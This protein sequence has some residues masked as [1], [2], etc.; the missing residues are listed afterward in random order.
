MQADY[1]ANHGVRPRQFGEAG[2]AE[3]P[4]G[5]LFLCAGCRRQVIVCSCCDRGQ[6]YC[7]GGCAK[8]A[9]QRTVQRAGRRYQASHRGR[10]MHAARMSRWRARQQKVT[11]HGSPAPPAGDLLAPAAMTATRA[12]VAPAE[13]ARLPG[14][15]CHWCG[16]T[17][18]PL[19]RQRFL[20]RR[21][22]HRGRLA[23]DPTGPP[24]HGDA[25]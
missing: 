6:V 7:T 8:A 16:R 9:R 21:R 14:P 25:A 23:H 4:S 17:C 2:D 5:R 12:A 22:R 19:L 11:H 10:R 20:R 3:P 15:H 24:R 18:L 13:Q 1:P